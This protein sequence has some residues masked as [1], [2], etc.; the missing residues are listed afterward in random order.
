MASQ[1]PKTSSHQPLSRKEVLRAGLER[2]AQQREL[3]EL[4][5]RPQ[6]NTTRSKGGALNSE[7]SRAD[8]IMKVFAFD[9]YNVE[10]YIEYVV[11]YI[12]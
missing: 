4:Q 1:K 7:R 5:R 3:R 9:F 11:L 8:I 2:L 6:T 12:V 10:Y